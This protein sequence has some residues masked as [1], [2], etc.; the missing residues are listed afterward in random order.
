MFNPM[1]YTQA[2]E[3]AEKTDCG[4]FS[5]LSDEGGEFTLVVHPQ[6]PRRGAL[7]GRLSMR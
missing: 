5:Y 1:T 7:H 3:M 2:V 4:S 6:L